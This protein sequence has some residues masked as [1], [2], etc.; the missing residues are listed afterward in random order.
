MTV[1]CN[2]TLLQILK[3]MLAHSRLTPNRART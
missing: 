1:T 3:S 2:M